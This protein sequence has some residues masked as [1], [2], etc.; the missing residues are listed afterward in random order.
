MLLIASMIP[1]KRSISKVCGTDIHI[2]R[3]GSIKSI[4]VSQI[5][6]STCKT[7][8]RWQSFVAKNSEIDDATCYQHLLTEFV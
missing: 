8:S 5:H 1:C 7:E 6:S 4:L 2:V 3:A